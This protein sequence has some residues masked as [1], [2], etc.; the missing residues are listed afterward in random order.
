[1]LLT[2]KLSYGM[3]E[4]HERGDYSETKDSRAISKV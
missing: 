3:I 1:M 4:S 2:S